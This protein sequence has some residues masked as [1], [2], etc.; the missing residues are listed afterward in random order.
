M[1][2]IEIW[3]PLC[4]Y[5]QLP[6]PQAPTHLPNATPTLSGLSSLCLLPEEDM[7]S[8]SWSGNCIL[9]IAGSL[10]LKVGNSGNI[11]KLLVPFSTSDRQQEN[12]CVMHQQIQ[13]QNCP[14]DQ[15]L[16][17]RLPWVLK[18]SRPSLFKELSSGNF[19]WQPIYA[20]NACLD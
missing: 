17:D 9:L 10:A 12:F 8:D 6:L 15:I 11:L 20:L 4:G 18:L 16:P 1:A 7:I 2:S 5:F 19:L 13:R 14:E 3:P